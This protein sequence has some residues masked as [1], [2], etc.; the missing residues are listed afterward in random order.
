MLEGNTGLLTKTRGFTLPE[1]FIFN[2]S[3][4]VSVEAAEGNTSTKEGR[5]DRTL[6]RRI[7]NEELHKCV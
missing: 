1:Y 4:D 7:Q 3:E 6:L 2:T 5:S